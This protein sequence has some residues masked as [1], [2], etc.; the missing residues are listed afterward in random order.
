MTGAK[1]LVVTVIILAVSGGV[2]VWLS[3]TPQ[4]NALG[5]LVVASV[6]GVIA[7]KRIGRRIIAVLLIITALALGFLGW[8]GGWQSFV[9]GLLALATAA[10]GVLVWIRGNQWPG[11]SSRYGPRSNRPADPWSELDAGRDPTS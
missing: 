6:A 1:G 5:W 9:I 3:T 2:I 7:T 10:M 11:L 4:V 8:D